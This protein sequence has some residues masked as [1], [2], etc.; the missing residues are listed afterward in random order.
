MEIDWTGVKIYALGW[1]VA[2]VL[3]VL[4]SWSWVTYGPQIVIEI[5]QRD[6]SEQIEASIREVDAEIA[7]QISTGE[8]P[9]K[10]LYYNDRFLGYIPPQ[11]R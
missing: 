3:G 9:G 8:I 10:R 7:R 5:N 2:I 1:A 11:K 4:V 6:Y